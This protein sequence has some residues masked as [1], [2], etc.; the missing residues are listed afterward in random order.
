MHITLLPRLVIGLLLALLTLVA[1]ANEGAHTSPDDHDSDTQVITLTPTALVENGITTALADAGLI[2]RH[3]TVYGR[4]I[5]PTNRQTAIVARYP[6]LIR[7][8]AVSAGDQVAQGDLLARV[9]ASDSLQTY[10]IRS[11]LSGQVLS[12]AARTGEITDNAPLMVI[13]DL[14]QLWAQLEIFPSQRSEVKAGLTVHVE[15]RAGRQ[16]GTIASLLPAPTAAP[17]ALARVTL[18]NPKQQLMPGDMVSALIDV[19]KVAVALRVD[20]RAI[21]QLD[22]ETVA[23]VANGNLF[24][25]QPVTIGRSDGRFVEILSGI[26]VGTRYV[27]QNSH[28]LKADLEKADAEHSH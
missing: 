28:L 15:T 16:N 4:L 20:R 7:E 2:E 26:T 21:Q 14:H 13:G 18:E 24:K 3:L 6:G 22:G 5:T 25:P 8:I 23:F 9:E 19:E 27:V 11:P 1:Q 10:D 17:F 12:L